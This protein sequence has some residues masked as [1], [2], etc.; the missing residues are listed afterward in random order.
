MAVRTHQP[1]RIRKHLVII[2]SASL[3]VSGLTMFETHL[4]QIRTA[5]AFIF[6]AG[7]IG[8][9][10]GGVQ[11]GIR[12]KNRPYYYSP[13]KPR[14]KRPRGVTALG[15]LYI[16]G[17]IISYTGIQLLFQGSQITSHSINMGKQMELAYFRQLLPTNLENVFG[18]ALIAVGV[19][20]FIIG[21]GTLKGKAWA[22]KPL[23]ISNIISIPLTI[24][25]TKDL[26]IFELAMTIFFLVLYSAI[27][28]YLYRPHVRAYFGRI[29]N[30]PFHQPSLI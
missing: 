13:S 12:S 28:Y 5:G 14:I 27:I 6:L 30:Q 16:I 24:Y 23:I 1:S 15:I 17:G 4:P 9:I 29:G 11:E 22:W 10:V 2:I 19:T 8:L 25:N 20:L 21:C 3:F 26:S 18:V 7:L